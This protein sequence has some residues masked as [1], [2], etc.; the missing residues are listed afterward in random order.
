MS[1]R[2]FQMSWAKLYPAYLAKVE[3]K[4]KPKAQLDEII[5]WLLGYDAAALAASLADD[6]NVGTFF[7]EAPALNPKRAEI[8]GVVCGVRVEAMEPGLMQEV[9][10]LDKLVD[11]LARGKKF[12]NIFR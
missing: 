3:K 10:Y 2:L 9:R 5:H 1:E 11:E 7:R 12:E 6:R 8:K 4:G